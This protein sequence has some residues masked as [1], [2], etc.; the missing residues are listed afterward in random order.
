MFDVILFIGISFLAYRIFVVFLN[1]FFNTKLPIRQASESPEN[2]ISILIPARNEAHNLPTLFRVLSE[3]EEQV[4]EII[5]LNDQSEDETGE[6]LDI[7]QKE[8]SNTTRKVIQGAPLPEGWLGKNYACHRLAEAAQGTH[9]LF[10]DAD[11]AHLDKRLIMSALAQVA[12]RSLS[13]LSIFPDQYM[14]SLGEKL[15]VPIMHVLLLSLLPLRWIF[16]MP[17]PSMA[18]ANGQFML[19]EANGYREHRWHERV[20]S[21]IVEDIA[22]MQEIKKAKLKGLT[23]TANGLIHTRMYHD[24]EEGV[25]G[26][27][28]NILAGFGNSIPG[29]VFYVTL[30]ILWPLWLFFQ[31]LFGEIS[32]VWGLAFLG[33]IIFIRSGI[34][35][36]SAQSP[37]HNIILHPIHIICL[38][39]VSFRSVLN[40]LRK[41][42]TW[43]GRNVQL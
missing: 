1:L 8:A 29:L 14:Q 38:G 26:F 10:L 19:F 42:N 27:G 24:F 30:V 15:I 43:K 28:K 21:V 5:I 33:G 34:S 16:S 18:A 13:L 3:I 40:R 7:W 20:K 37:L 4:L 39:L 6:L 25:A 36:L 35:Y 41:Q 11:V 22:I 12:K 23:F 2:H 9:F 17:F 31:I 32:A